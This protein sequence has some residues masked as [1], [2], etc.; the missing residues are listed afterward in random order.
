MRRIIILGTD[1]YQIVVSANQHVNIILF[2]NCKRDS[3]T[4]V[5]EEGHAGL[6]HLLYVISME[7]GPFCLAYF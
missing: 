6:P 1:K 3:W 2:N 4:R 5:S 7:E